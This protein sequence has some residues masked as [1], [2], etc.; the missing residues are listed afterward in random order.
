MSLKKFFLISCF[1]MSLNGLSQDMKEGFTYLETG[2][3]KEAEVFFKDVLKNYPKNKTARLCYG[4]AVGLNGNS[5]KA[6]NLFINLLNDFPNDFEVKLNY[7]ESL[8]WDKKFD[9][10]E[11]YYEK[12]IKEN[13]KSFSALLGYAN[14]LSNLK[15][16][17]K[18]LVYVDKALEVS[19]NNPNALVS[20]KYMRLG[21]ANEYLNKQEYSKAEAIL[22]ENFTNF[23]D[24]KETLLNLA[25]LYLISNQ[26]S[27]AEETY[28]KLGSNNE[29][30][31]ISLNGLALV[32]HLKSKNKLALNTSKTSVNSLP[33]NASKD[34]K[35]QTIERYIQALIWNKKFKEA[36]KE[37]NNLFKSNNEPENWMLSLRATLNIYKS[38]F[39][40]SIEDYNLILKKDSASF[41]GNLGKAN[42]LKALGYYNKAYLGAE[43]T[44]SFYDNQKDAT[45]FINKLDESFTPF[46]EAK[47]SYSFDNGNNDAYMYQL[48]GEYSFSTKFKVLASYN[49]RFTKN[50]VTNLEATSNNVL[51]GFS[52]QLFNNVVFKSNLGVTSSNANS[53]D[54]TQLLADVA[55]EIKPFKLQNL[56]IGYKR[57]IQNF[58]AELIDRE[59]VQNNF[60]LNY[61]LSTNFNLGWFTQYYYT[62]QNDS[63]TRNLL[64]TSL[65]YNILEKPSL[66]AGVNYQY[67][68][69]KNQVPTIYFSPSK[70][71][72]YEIFINL[73]KDENIAKNKT[74]FYDLTA[75]TGLQFIEDDAKQSTYRIQ[76]KLGY[77]FSE[78]SLLNIYA[79]Q[80]NIASATAAGFTFTEIGL[81]FKWL[82][83]KKPVFRKN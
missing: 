48:N 58:N 11:N 62:S 16:Y 37:I 66:K 54:F 41:D 28:I 59:I 76:G 3:Y 83:L 20:K 35:N 55:F 70:F 10:A 77:K 81:R 45:Q 61:N 38:N 47:T 6:L 71:N 15:K 60:I 67:I 23:K 79:L 52:Y 50:P 17:N 13:D 5:T 56:E 44:L 42:A 33:S 26:Y 32:Q 57:E 72:A 78:R 39:D 8:L 53:N 14:T 36:D 24:D 49:H 51:V 68:T 18:A 34:I 25:N 2:K 69:F 22:R 46:V 7:A 40:K 64:F 19:P 63:N 75:A 27:K 12:L 74:W 82:F 9:V 21:L 65:Y 73:I 80:S 4:R 29:N 30:K 43:N 31:N 1:L